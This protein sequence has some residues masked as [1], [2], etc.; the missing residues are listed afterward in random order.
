MLL[1]PFKVVLD[2]CVLYPFSLRDVLL[3]AAAEGL[4]QVY[5]SETILDEAFRN[6]VADGRV[7]EDNAARLAATM[8]RAFPRRRSSTTRR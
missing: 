7:T 2:A 1:A 5:W 3:Q 8:R 6:L 4:Y